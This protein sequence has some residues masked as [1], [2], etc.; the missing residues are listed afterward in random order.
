MYCGFT[1]SSFQ[2]PPSTQVP[3]SQAGGVLFLPRPSRHIGVF[4]NRCSAWE[5]RDFSP[6]VSEM[7]G[8]L[9]TQGCLCNSSNSIVYDNESL[10]DSLSF[11]RG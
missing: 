1:P 7:R 6:L 2:F 9:T 10:I 4:T 11:D 5:P 3:T 8:N